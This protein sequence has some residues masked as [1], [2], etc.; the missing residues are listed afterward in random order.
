MK[1]GKDMRLPVAYNGKDVW[2]SCCSLYS[3]PQNEPLMSPQGEGRQR[4][5]ILYDSINIQPTLF[6]WRD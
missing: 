4:S 1:L 2:Y 3:G 6:N 5:K